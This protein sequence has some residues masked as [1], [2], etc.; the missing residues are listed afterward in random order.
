MSPFKL[1]YAVRT[2]IFHVN[3]CKLVCKQRVHGYTCTQVGNVK[4]RDLPK[5]NMN[6][7]NNHPHSIKSSNKCSKIHFHLNLV[8]FKS[9]VMN[10]HLK[11][12]IAKVVLLL[13]LEYLLTEILYRYHDWDSIE[14][15]IIDFWPKVQ[16]GRFVSPFKTNGERTIFDGS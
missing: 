8:L 10:F 11:L 7:Q 13:F 6:M 4:W 1:R 9:V 15:I 3:A 5:G 14:R 16:R 12:V 2:S